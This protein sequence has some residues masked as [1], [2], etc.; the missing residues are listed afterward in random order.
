[1]SHL[2]VILIHF[3]AIFILSLIIG[4]IAVIVTSFIVDKQKKTRKLFFAFCAPFIGLYTL[5]ICAFIGGT[6]ISEIKDV[7]IGIGDAWYVPIKDNYELLFI[8]IPDYGAI[9]NKETGE[10]YLSDISEIEQRGD[11]ILGKKSSNEYFSFN[12][13]NEELNEFENEKVL[14]SSNGNE[15]L[16]FKKV[17]DFYLERKNEAM[18]YW[19]YLI[20]A[21]SLLFSFGNLWIVRYI[22][23]FSFS[24]D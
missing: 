9:S 14:I 20:G 23:L 12:T 18:G 13:K 8:D 6:I 1:M 17:Y 22:M 4:I 24:K 19:L 5:Y 7:D 3:V 10:T 16:N 21:L 15:K 11:L 2:F